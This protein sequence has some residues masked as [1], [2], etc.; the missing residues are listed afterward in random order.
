MAM[1]AAVAAGDDVRVKKIGRLACTFVTAPSA[2]H[3]GRTVYLSINKGKAV[4]SEAPTNSFSA[5][6]ALG[7]LVSLTEVEF[8]APSLRGVNG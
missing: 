5:I 3:I 4:I 1:D 6:V 7:R 8:R 2:E